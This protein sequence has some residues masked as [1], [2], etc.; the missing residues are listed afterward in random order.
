M[1]A[2]YLIHLNVKK[3]LENQK[4]IDM[5]LDDIKKDINLLL[6]TPQE[7]CKPYV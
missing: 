4:N 7:F 5:S 1:Y 2:V 6:N 3:I